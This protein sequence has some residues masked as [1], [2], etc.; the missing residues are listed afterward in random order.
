MPRP[1]LEVP[2]V[3]RIVLV[4]HPGYLMRSG[5]V[6]QQR[7]QFVP[8]SPLQSYLHQVYPEQGFLTKPFFSVSDVV[9]VLKGLISTLKLYDSRNPTVVICDP[10]L[11]IALQAKALHV[12]QIRDRVLLQLRT[13]DDPER[14]NPF[15]VHGNPAT[16]VVTQCVHHDEAPKTIQQRPSVVA[17]NYPILLNELFRVTPELQRVFD[18]LDQYEEGTT[19]FRFKHISKL[20][21]QYILKNKLSLFDGRNSSVAIVEGSLLEDV[22]KLK[23]LH[24]SQVPTLV[25]QCLIPLPIEEQDNFEGPSVYNEPEVPI[26][27]HDEE[28]EYG[29]TRVESGFFEE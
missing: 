4:P 14:L 22:F 21:S 25:R 19:V 15:I 23:C 29:P 12:T 7:R 3:R 10:A 11:G 6:P 17:A 27:A 24:S 1:T 13:L 18:S 8:N 16:P 5:G 26:P 20:L 2:P 9:R 28:E